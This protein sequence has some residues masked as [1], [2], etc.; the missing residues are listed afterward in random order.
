VPQSDKI[1]ALLCLLIIAVGN[2][3]YL[4]FISFVAV[5]LDLDPFNY[6][7]EARIL[8]DPTE[9]EIMKHIMLPF[10]LRL[11]VSAIAVF[12][13]TKNFLFLC[14]VMVT[15]LQTTTGGLFIVSSQ[16][17]ATHI[18]P[19]YQQY[20]LINQMTE[21][22]IGFVAALWLAVAHVSLV[23]LLW[24]TV[25]GYSKTRY[26]LLYVSYPVTAAFVITISVFA[27]QHAVAIFELSNETVCN[28]RAGSVVRI[29]RDETFEL[30]I[31]KSIRSQA[32]SLKPCGIKVGK[33]KVQKKGFQ[34]DWLS[35]LMD[36]LTNAV[37][38]MKPQ[39]HAQIA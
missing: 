10:S 31:I 24:L 30:S 34:V 15:L 18:F 6:I 27:M 13:G 32:K 14:I 28:W 19:A 23:I 11:F 17:T 8:P 9:R 38:L 26:F 20:Q 21:G 37:L 39:N 22:L 5:V 2:V 36:H 4:L 25:Y 35:L 29:P 3:P 12:E 16:H 7:F 1:G 33:M